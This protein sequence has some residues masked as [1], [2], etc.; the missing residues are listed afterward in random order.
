[1]VVNIYKNYVAFILYEI[2]ISNISINPYKPSLFFYG[3]ANSADPNEMLQNS[4]EIK[5]KPSD[6][7]ILMNK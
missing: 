6:L 3:K 2:Q 5:L 1:M 7:Q 4:G